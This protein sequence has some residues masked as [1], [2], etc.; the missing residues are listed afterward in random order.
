MRILH[1]SLGLP[2]NR[3]GGL[4]KYATD[5]MIS[6]TASGNQVYLL[7][8][9]EYTFWRTPKMK[10]VKDSLFNGV[11]VYKIEN[12]LIVPLRHGVRYPT[13]ITNPK[14]HFT[15]NDLDLFYHQIRPDIIHVHT[16]MGL[17]QELL[18]FLKDKGVKILFTTHDYYGLCLK[19]NFINQMGLCCDFPG[20]EKCAICNQN[21]PGNLFLRLRNSD[22]LLQNKKRL[23][24]NARRL[25]VSKT[26]FHNQ[27]IPIPKKVDEYGHLI[28]YYRHLFDQ[29][30]FFHFNSNVTKEG[31]EKHL[32]PIKSAVLPI[33]H[34]NIS[35]NRKRRSIEK[36]HVRIGYIGSRAAYKGYPLLKDIL[37]VLN[38]KGISNWTLQVW[39]GA[40]GKDTLCDRIN[41]KGEF[42][43]AEMDGVFNQL[44]LLIVPS[45]WKETFS[46]I[47]LEA[48]S[49]G[50]P[51]LVSE[52][53]GAK[54]IVETYDPY[55]IFSPSKEEL[56]FKLEVILSNT[57]RIEEYNK[58]I[59]LGKFE[60]SLDDHGQKLQELYIN[61][62]NSR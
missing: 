1:F 35:D 47:T 60:Y 16:L 52:N 4:T 45:I 6:Q 62:L 30:D 43:A 22:Y 10:I 8:P 48:L 20:K 31:Y 29:I 25:E 41:Y 27:L 40:V 38:T 5:L 15:S 11:L 7:Y 13:A 17:P 58:K 32:T 37:C 54:D 34:A 33:S 24:G 46:L 55:F 12:P 14:Y 51:V 19:V 9:G 44:D 57:S 49:F 39:G 2:P 26:N 56:Q 28:E 61:L 53:V 50:I 42:T 18:L 21:S 23:A 36:D 3:S 59:C